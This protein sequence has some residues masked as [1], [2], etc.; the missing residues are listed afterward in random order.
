MDSVPGSPRSPRSPLP[1]TG[2]AT[3]SSKASFVATPDSSSSSSSSSSSRSTNNN[4]NIN[5]N[6]PG[7]YFDGQ[8]Q[9][10]HHHQGTAAGTP[11]TAHVS[12]TS[13]PSQTV[14]RRQYQPVSEAD[15]PNS[16]STIVGGPARPDTFTS[17]SWAAWLQA[18]SRGNWPQTP[19]T[20]YSAPPPLHS[21]PSSTSSAAASDATA[22][23]D[24]GASDPTTA[25]AA[26]ASSGSASSSSALGFGP[27][28]TAATA[29]YA[30]I[31]ATPP[32]KKKKRER[33]HPQSSLD[34]YLSHGYIQ[35]P[36]GGH[37]VRRQRCDAL[38]RFRLIAADQ[39]PTLDRYTALA[40]AVFRADYAAIFMSNLRNNSQMC[41][42]SSIGAPTNTCSVPISQTICG[43]AMLIP[44][45]V[46]VI[47][48]IR[49]DW[50]FHGLP[51]AQAGG[52]PNT[53]D[54]Q[55]L[56]FYASAP[57]RVSVSGPSALK[58]STDK[59]R[60]V[61]IG[62]LCILS[63]EARYN[64]TDAD[65]EL[66]TSIASMCGD[67]FENDYLQHRALKVSEMQRAMSS[68]ARTLTEDIDH[69]EDETSTSTAAG[70]AAV[71]SGPSARDGQLK[72]CPLRVEQAC[73]HLRKALHADSV[74]AVDLSTFRVS[75]MQE[76]RSVSGTSYPLTPWLPSPSP[77]LSFGG[78]VPTESSTPADE[79]S[80]PSIAGSSPEA[81][82]VMLPSGSVATTPSTVQT[83][84]FS[85][86]APTSTTTASNSAG[87][88]SFWHSHQMSTASSRTSLSG[89]ENNNSAAA[90]AQQ[91]RLQQEVCTQLCDT[92]TP[93]IVTHLGAPELVP[94]LDG[95][96][97]KK[98]LSKW[99]TQWRRG[100]NALRPQLFRVANGDSEIGESEEDEEDLGSRYGGTQN[101]LEALSRQASAATVPSSPSLLP[102]RHSLTPGPSP[103]GPVPIG[104]H[105]RTYSVGVLEGAHAANGAGSAP[106]GR[107]NSSAGSVSES[108]L[109]GLGGDATNPL[110][111]LLPNARQYAALPIF[112]ISRGNPVVLLIATFLDEVA[113]EESELLFFEG[114]GA[115][116]YSSLLAQQ[117]RAVDRAQLSLIRGLQH[118][119][120]TPLHGILGI[121]DAIQSH[122]EHGDTTIASDP[123]LL[124]NLLES[125]RLASTSLNGLLDDVLTFGEITGV[126]K[127][128]R[129]AALDAK[130]SAVD[131]LDLGDLIEEVALEE[132][133]VRKMSIKQNET[134]RGAASHS[135]ETAS[136]G[137]SST[138]SDAIETARLTALQMQMQHGIAGLSLTTGPSESEIQTLQDAVHLPERDVSVD[139]RSVDTDTAS[140]DGTGEDGL[141]SRTVRPSSSR[142]SSM[143][144]PELP[145]ELVI[146]TLDLFDRFRCD[147]TKVQKA[148][149][150]VIS[151]ALRFTTRGVVKI[152]ARQRAEE[153]SSKGVMVD[154]EIA[155]TGPGMSQEFINT[156]LMEPFVK[157]SAF[158]SGVG[159]GNVIAASLVSQMGGHLHIASTVGRGTQVTISL[160]LTPLGPTRTMMSS[161]GGYA[162]HAVS[163]IGC[164]NAGITSACD[165]LRKMLRAKNVLPVEEIGG[166]PDLLV[167]SERVLNATY[168]AE[169]WE[170]SGFD[171]SVKKALMSVPPHARVLVV[172]R[173]ETSADR[174]D[175]GPMGARP[176]HVVQ[177]PYGPSK[178]RALNAFL[179]HEKPFVLRAVPSPAAAHAHAHAKAGEALSTARRQ[180][181]ASSTSSTR[182]TRPSVGD[183]GVDLNRGSIAPVDAS[184]S[185]AG[186]AADPGAAAERDESSLA[187]G[188]T[189]ADNTPVAPIQ[190]P[191]EVRAAV[192]DAVSEA[193][194]LRSRLEQEQGQRQEQGAFKLDEVD[195][196]A[197]GSLAQAAVQQM[198][199]AAE[200]K[201]VEHEFRVL[202]VEDNPINLKLLT[203]LCKRLKMKYEEAKDG[204]EAVVKYL[205][206]RPS[207]V[208]LDISLPEQDGFQAAAQMRSHPPFTDHPPR[209]VAIT[210]LSSEQDKIRGLTQCGMDIWLTK[211]VSTRALQKDLLE[212]EHNWKALHAPPAAEEPQQQQQQQQQE[213]QTTPV[214]AN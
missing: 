5:I 140:P 55:P 149:R 192:K 167:V 80:Q 114:V 154:I 196:A 99:L 81:G 170:S 143:R 132:L 16:I 187:P 126:H 145:P 129:Q 139:A 3:A 67:A 198:A 68:L 171:D 48:N 125:I 12:R 74:T 159:L 96:L 200:E 214:A 115:V 203:T 37:A 205:S 176:I 174:I 163:F 110:G 64:W 92:E 210:A 65:S 53:A 137:L 10:A 6:R 57:I 30:S 122:E 202:V 108:I 41:I 97:Q 14:H 18:Y 194:E 118:E 32:S 119:F 199:H 72:V 79:H 179:Q 141:G 47:P 36:P 206:F 112:P 7:G 95:I 93:K 135:D 106:I 52:Y 40:K 73:K 156:R 62:R 150:K 208:L 82:K 91:Q 90:A 54:G 104:N 190:D 180:R 94:Q 21:Y 56:L 42:A 44:D 78:S 100:R 38:R 61:T 204:V 181:E 201:V 102:D 49:E 116:L 117:A 169:A 147:R 186:R 195:D 69:G 60:T 1:P 184:Q 86:G 63:R 153:T 168:S 197:V 20:E 164:D 138:D 24:V 59:S 23:I 75:T 161:G 211:P 83:P 121:V 160:P 89:L 28:Q 88:H 120:R 172:S 13:A 43:H 46:L 85:S 134:I 173:G 158:D 45:K 113:V 103:S 212:M 27:A 25:R 15:P 109:S 130:A 19:A 84:G 124:H 51:C 177:M 33:T 157:G 70:L 146:D 162:C 34:F 151:N 142:T 50:L 39:R 207:V 136:Q 175:F 152:T 35:P 22:S 188:L 165:F 191:A 209:I 26:T 213:E 123:E 31:A 87:Y 2:P 185:I 101:P 133:Q 58:R 11:S 71:M 178:L 76:R 111:L 166:L 4:N 144:E 105:A 182:A 193:D 183:A 9:Q 17:A 155:D 29:S 107:S 8:S 98:A 127:S 128:S 66:L 77:S 148:L 189:G 131:D